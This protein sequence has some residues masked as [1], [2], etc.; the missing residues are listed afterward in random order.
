[1]CE[2]CCR[3]KD[4]CRDPCEE[5]CS[6][7]R[8]FVQV[9]RGPVSGG[10]VSWSAV[11]GEVVLYEKSYPIS[12]KT[13]RILVDAKVTAEFQQSL[14]NDYERFKLYVDDV[15]VDTSGDGANLG[16]ITG[17][18]VITY[19]NSLASDSLL[20]GVNVYRKCQVRVKLTA[21]A[22]SSNG[23]VGN[24][25]NNNGHYLG[26]KGFVIRIVGD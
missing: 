5:K 15:L 9:V 10:N 25:D 24:I 7:P 13:K 26:D 8:S 20:A 6:E 17:E 4:P 19:T 21:Q 3:C 14:P 18:T 16:T 11:Q 23:A 1:M 12:K 2:Y 22:I